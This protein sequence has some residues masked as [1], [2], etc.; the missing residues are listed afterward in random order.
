M[1]DDGLLTGWRSIHRWDTALKRRV[2]TPV[3][4]DDLTGVQLE[5]SQG[6]EGRGGVDRTVAHQHLI[7]GQVVALKDHPGPF[8]PGLDTAPGV[9]DLLGGDGLDL[10]GGFDLLVALD[11]S[12]IPAQLPRR[13]KGK[14]DVGESDDGKDTEHPAGPE[15]CPPAL[16]LRGPTVP[17]LTCAANSHEVYCPV[18]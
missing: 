1:A 12:A 18:R 8:L 15:E 10:E 17:A 13:Q 9:K 3:D 11:D 4:Q 5:G 14:G 6:M 7:L 16:L 2:E